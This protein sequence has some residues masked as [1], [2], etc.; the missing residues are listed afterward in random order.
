MVMSLSSSE[1]GTG[2]G[3]PLLPPRKPNILG[4]HTGESD[5]HLGI[6]GHRNI[7]YQRQA[8]LLFTYRGVSS[9]N[10]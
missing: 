8:Q 7:H 1:D 6:V 4:P 5:Q 2:R 3:V 10:F 9:T